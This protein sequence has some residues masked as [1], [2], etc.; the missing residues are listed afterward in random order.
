MKNWKVI[1]KKLSARV[2]FI[3]KKLKGLVKKARGF[4]QQ[5][6][7]RK[8]KEKKTDKLEDELQKL[9][10]ISVEKLIPFAL[11][12]K[13]EQCKIPEIESNKEKILALVKCNGKLDE[14]EARIITKIFKD[15][16]YLQDLAKI[17]RGEKLQQT[18]EL[19]EISEEPTPQVESD[20]E[21]VSDEDQVFEP[22]KEKKKNRRG[23]QARRAIWEKKYGEKAKHVVEGKVKKP[24]EKEKM[25]ESLHPSW[26]AKKKQ[27]AIVE[28]QGSKIVFDNSNEKQ[29]LE[30]LHPSWQAK[31]MKKEGIVEAKG[32]KLVFDD[33]GII[34]KKQEFGKAEEPKKESFKAQK[35]DNAKEELHPSWQAKKLKK[36][37]IVESKGSKI[38][39]DD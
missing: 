28:A 11:Y 8:L 34:T 21:W 19:S 3:Y 7:I 22:T 36:E 25:K 39:F 1:E 2:A 29:E 30:S 5:R 26:E 27:Q 13:V 32:S 14:L 6:V 37:G 17:I 9:K 23:Q 18:T 24:K 16:Q 20:E 33:E 38:V 12:R 10:K 31:K 4:Q 35:K 15:D